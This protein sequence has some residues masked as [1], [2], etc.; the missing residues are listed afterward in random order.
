[1]WAS[2]SAPQSKKEHAKGIEDWPM[3]QVKY[4]LI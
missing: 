2:E 3:L 1:M 4:E